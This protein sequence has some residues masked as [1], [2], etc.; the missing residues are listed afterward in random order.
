[1]SGK[2]HFRVFSHSHSEI[3]IPQASGFTLIAGESVALYSPTVGDPRSYRGSGADNVL[4]C[5]ALGGG[6]FNA[7]ARGL[8]RLPGPGCRGSSRSCHERS[9]IKDLH[10]SRS[11]QL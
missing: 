3:T 6:P 8:D 5:P 11:N 1:M 10:S 2:L 7:S 4:S 9:P